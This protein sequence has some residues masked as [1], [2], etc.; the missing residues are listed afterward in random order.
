MR[1]RMRIGGADAGEL[2]WAFFAL[3]R[4]ARNGRLGAHESRGE[5]YFSAEYRLRL[6]E[7]GGDF[8]DAGTLRLEDFA[9]RVEGDNPVVRTAFERSAGVLDETADEAG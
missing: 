4:L 3:R 1:H 6:A 9:L 5:G 8:E 2:A 7:D